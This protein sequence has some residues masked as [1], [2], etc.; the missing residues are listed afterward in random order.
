M[1]VRGGSVALTLNGTVGRTGI[2]LW[3][4]ADENHFQLEDATP[5]LAQRL[6]GGSPRGRVTLRGHSDEGASMIPDH[7]PGLQWSLPGKLFSHLR[8]L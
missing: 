7:Q 1:L 4:W 8:Q 6:V 2:L 3:D 5:T